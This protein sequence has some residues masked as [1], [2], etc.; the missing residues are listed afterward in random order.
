MHALTVNSAAVIFREY[1][2]PSSSPASAKDGLDLDAAASEARLWKVQADSKAGLAIETT[3]L[4]ILGLIATGVG[5]YCIVQ[6][7]NFANSDA[8]SHAVS[9]LVR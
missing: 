9:A 4:A 8:I 5:T 6:M 3:L 7:A 1:E 2:L